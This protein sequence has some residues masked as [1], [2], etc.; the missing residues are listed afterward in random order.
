MSEG[1]DEKNKHHEEFESIENFLGMNEP[2]VMID[3]ECMECG[4]IDPVPDF[5][6]DEFAFDLKQG[7][8]VE[9]V[10]PECNGTMREKKK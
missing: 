9:T 6:V 2:D 4:C 1:R 8:V 10:C 3:F 5:I 7:E